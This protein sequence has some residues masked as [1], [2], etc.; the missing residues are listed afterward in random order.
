M[1]KSK[2]FRK[3]GDNKPPRGKTNKSSATTITKKKTLADYIYNTGSARNASE[4]ISTTKF[5]LNHI[6]ITM[7]DGDD[8]VQAL[9]AKQEFDHKS[10]APALKQSLLPEDTDENKLK[11]AHEEK[12]FELEFQEDRK[13]FAERT[14]RYRKNKITV[15]ALIWKQCSERMRSSYNHAQ[16]S[17]R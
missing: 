9:Q 3:R 6:Q 16:I 17:R 14:E 2:N 4:Y 15:A 8:V 10:I 13:I 1:V 7:E 11:K 5:L 12:Q